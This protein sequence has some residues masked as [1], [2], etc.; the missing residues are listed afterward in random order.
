M[1]LHEAIIK[2]LKEKGTPMTTTEIANALNENKWYLKKD[3]SE[4]T[5]FQI[6]G[7]TKKLR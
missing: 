3:K 4:I 2:L 6:H 1:T 5:P 7:R